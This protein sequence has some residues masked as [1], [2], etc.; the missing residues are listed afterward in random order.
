MMCSSGGGYFLIRIIVVV[1]GYVVTTTTIDII[2]TPRLKKISGVLW[3]HGVDYERDKFEARKKKCAC[4][5]TST[6]GD[7]DDERRSKLLL[8]RTEAWLVEA[9]RKEVSGGGGRVSLNYYGSVYASAV[10]SLIVERHAP[11]E[12]P[13]DLPETLSFDLVR[14]QRARA[15]FESLADRAAVFALGSNH[16]GVEV[17]FRGLKHSQHGNPSSKNNKAVREVVIIII[18]VMMMMVCCF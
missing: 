11:L 7:D 8:R 6:G 17:L 3:L 13:E 10:M 4:S 9:I 16:N 5:S 1:V 12:K 14:F 15:E 2:I 18:V